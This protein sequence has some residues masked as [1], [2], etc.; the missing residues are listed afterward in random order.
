[1]D[2]TNDYITTGTTL[3]SADSITL[4]AWVNA[5]GAKDGMA[6]FGNINGQTGSNRQCLI[7]DNAGVENLTFTDGLISLSITLGTGTW[8][9]IVYTNRGTT[10]TLYLNGVKIAE[11]TAGSLTTAA[12]QNVEIGSCVG[13]SGR[14][15]YFQGKIDE[16]RLY[17]RALSA[18]EVAQ[19]YRLNTPTSVDTSLKGYWSFNAPDMASTTAYDRSGAGNSGTLTNGPAS[20]EGKLGQGL[21]FDGTDDYVSVADAAAFTESAL[22]VSF[23]KKNTNVASNS[24]Y[25]TKSAT[26]QRSWSVESSDAGRNI[27]FI[28]SNSS[29]SESEYGDTPTGSM[30]AGEWYFVTCVFDGSGLTNAERV[31]IY[32]NGVAQSVAFTGTIPASLV[33]NTQAVT[34]GGKASAAGFLGSL[35][36]ARIYNRALT[37]AEIKGLYDVGQSDWVNSSASQ[38]QGTGRLDSGL[39]GYWKLDDGS[40]TSATDSSTNGN[41]GTL[42]NSPTWTTGQ[43]GGAVNFDGV[44]DTLTTSKTIPNAGTVSLWVNTTAVLDSGDY[45]VSVGGATAGNS[46]FLRF[47]SYSG[48]NKWDFNMRGNFGTDVYVSGPTLTTDTQ[49][50]WHYLTAVWDTSKGASFYLDGTLLNSTTTTTD[51]FASMTLSIGNQSSNTWL[52]KIDEVRLYDRMLSADE[53][54]QLYRL[55]VPT[56][57]DTSLKGYWSFNGQDLSGTTAYDRS[58]SGNTGTLT[59]G[60]TITEGKIGQALQFDGTNDLVV[61]TNESSYRFSSDF[62]LSTWVKVPTTLAGYEAVIGKYA[63]TPSGWDFGI[64]SN[65]KAR[66]SLRGTSTLDVSS[67]AGPDL[68]DNQWHHV[69]TV[70]TPTS[71]ETYVDGIL[72]NTMTG[73]WTATTNTDSLYIGNRDSNG[74]TTFSGMIDEVRVYNRALTESEIK[75]LYNTSR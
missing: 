23:W 6:I 30:T 18:D 13:S 65:G 16:A 5:S 12:E 53:V 32:I 54:S 64:G 31:Q 40:G 20:T 35:D 36:E 45:Y 72:Q 50:G 7:Y 24:K 34:L 39:A 59:S 68:R 71:I 28:V 63:V 25:V 56:G 41:T 4:S 67:G 46:M 38:P 37:V 51:A 15:D 47:N 58:G 27:R 55:A 73:T 48:Y 33:N 43:V 52:G 62:S 70:N 21:S 29:S 8:Q 11:N 3:I 60:P 57:V 22:T 19:L 61:V 10:N 75:A 2:G 17:R 1:M 66:M 42:T 74:T 49:Q 9:H 26:N 44:D 69:V 14:T